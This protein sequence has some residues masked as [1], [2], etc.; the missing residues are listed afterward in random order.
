MKTCLVRGGNYILKRKEDWKTKLLGS[1]K[2]E[3]VLKTYFLS[4]KVK[5]IE[6]FN[7]AV[8]Y[9][10]ENNRSYQISVFAGN[11][12]NEVFALANGNERAFD[13]WC[14]RTA[15]KISD[16]N[17]NDIPIF[18]NK[19]RKL[20]ILKKFKN[21]KDQ[22]K[23]IE[24]EPHNPE[25]GVPKLGTIELTS[26]CNFKCPHCYVGE[27][28]KSIDIS[29]KTVQRLLKELKD[30]GIKS[31]HFTGGEVCTRKDIG[32]IIE[33]AYDLGFH[34]TM[35]TNGL[36]LSDD[37]ILIVKRYVARLNITVYG[38][39]KETY[40]KFS[41]DPCAFDKIIST[42]NNIKNQKQ[43]IL[44]LIFT[45]TPDNYV[46]FDKFIIFSKKRKLPFNLG[47]TVPVGLALCDERLFSNDAYI[48]FIEKIEEKYG[49]AISEKSKFRQRVCKLEQITILVDGRVQICSL[50]RD[51]H[52]DF[53]NIY[54]ESIIK[55][56]Q[57]KMLPFFLSI[58]VDSIEICKECEYK[59]LCG[60]EC[61]ALWRALEST[62]KAKCPPCQTICSSR[63]FFFQEI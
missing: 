2:S 23:S 17:L 45:L 3:F 19:M 62:K 32:A 43:D 34:I 16:E 27:K 56:W 6:G 44:S 14:F 47:K 11:F 26:R 21:E 20:N 25:I 10:F 35:T 39:S 4:P 46:D 63:R 53:G 61:L 18:L 48:A 5:V 42:I 33:Y 13:K 36:L 31:V 7:K 52:F 57:N 28:T 60:G 50:L 1:I 29:F 15:L 22:F 59:Y 38:L 41:S 30:L 37:L 8:V 55:I 54:K 24:V 9:D 49:Q 40:S 51:A 12:L 58:K